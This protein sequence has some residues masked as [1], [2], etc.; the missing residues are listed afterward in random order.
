MPQASTAPTMHAG[1]AFRT[2]QWS[3]VL[4]AWGDDSFKSRA[5]LEE[6]CKR[7]W[8]PLYAYVRRRGFNEA[9]AA[10]LTQSFFAAIIEKQSLTG[11]SPGPTRFR[12]FLLTA[13]KNFLANEWKRRIG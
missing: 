8:F 9:D 3:M 2:T 6:L 13:M 5:A 1:P 12:A 4:A 10:D 11:V 7:Y